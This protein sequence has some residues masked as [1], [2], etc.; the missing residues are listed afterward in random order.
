MQ[1]PEPLRIAKARIHH[2][3]AGNAESDV[4]AE[5]TPTAKTQCGNKVSKTTESRLVMMNALVEGEARSL[6]INS[7]VCI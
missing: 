1:R 4:E 2:R 5:S 6:I 7:W 3:Y